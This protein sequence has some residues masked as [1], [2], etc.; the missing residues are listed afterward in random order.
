[1]GLFIWRGLSSL[2]EGDQRIEQP[3]GA[4]RTFSTFSAIVLV[5]YLVIAA[6][7]VVDPEIW[8]SR[9][10]RFSLQTQGKVVLD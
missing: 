5:L 8:T 7:V 1:M 10:V 4:L 2:L 9:Q 6:R 3:M